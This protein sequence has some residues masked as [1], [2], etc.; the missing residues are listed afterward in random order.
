MN[1]LTQDIATIVVTM[2]MEIAVDLVETTAVSGSS[3][4]Y[5]SAAAW[6]TMDV[7]V[8]MAV[9]TAVSGLFSYYSSVVAWDVT[10]DAVAIVAANS[11]VHA[12]KIFPRFKHF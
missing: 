12:G 4:Y 2:D 9:T 10:T 1:H 7:A 8:T 6:E 11:L 3:F 5:S